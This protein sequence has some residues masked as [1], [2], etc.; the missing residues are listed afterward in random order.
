MRTLTLLALAACHDGGGDDET[1]TDPGSVQ[2]CL[3][4]PGVGVDASR[5]SWSFSGTLDSLGDAPTRSA[6]GVCRG[7]LA[8]TLTDDD[9]ET[10][11]LA[12][13]ATAG[14]GDTEQEM[15]PPL[16]ASVGQRVDVE[17][18]T[19]FDW[20]VEVDVM[21]R[22]ASG[23]LLAAAEGYYTETW[24]EVTSGAGLTVSDA[25]ATR[26]LGD[27][28]CGARS[29][30]ALRF[31]ADDT[32]DLDVWVE[33]TLLWESASLQA[34]NVGAWSFDGRIDCTDTWGPSPWIV[35]RE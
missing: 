21:V 11:T 3:D 23:P 26:A 35:F 13:R 7:G 20:A 17:V 6:V 10:W 5:S 25:G 1:A 22:D 8:A 28:G 33:G 19:W 24:A 18:R 29:A 27:D 32:I 15:T 9:G 30:H 34:R 2:V 4:G 14:R 16:A 31:A 12:W